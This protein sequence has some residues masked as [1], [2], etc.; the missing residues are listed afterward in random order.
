MRG[1]SFQRKITWKD[2]PDPVRKG[3]GGKGGWGENQQMSTT[4]FGKNRNLKIGVWGCV[5]RKTLA[6]GLFEDVWK[7]MNELRFKRYWLAKSLHLVKL[8]I[9]IGFALLENS[10]EHFHTVYEI[11][12][13]VYKV[14]LHL[15]FHFAIRHHWRSIYSNSFYPVQHVWLSRKNDQA[16]QK[17]KNTIWRDRASIEPYMAGKLELKDNRTPMKARVIYWAKNQWGVIA[18]NQF[19]RD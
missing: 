1:E 3:K 15:T 6:L 17:A 4:M 11:Y 12:F 9:N 2:I 19:Q 18:K 8:P 7:R 14:P 13:E 10:S 5:S 16:Y